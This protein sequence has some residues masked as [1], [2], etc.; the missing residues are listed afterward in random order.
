MASPLGTPACYLKDP[1]MKREIRLG[2]YRQDD[3]GRTKEVP[4]D[5]FNIN[6]ST[7]SNICRCFW[8][9]TSTFST[10]YI[11]LDLNWLL[12]SCSSSCSLNYK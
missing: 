1:A 4:I 11:D 3:Q 2:V 10:K 6:Q 9:F 8:Q 5:F 12:F 7:E